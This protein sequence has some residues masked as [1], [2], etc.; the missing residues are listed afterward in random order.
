MDM[1]IT[2]LWSLV[3]QKIANGY[4]IL[5]QYLIS[6]EEYKIKLKLKET[7]GLIG[8]V[9]RRYL[10]LCIQKVKLLASMAPVGLFLTVEK[11]IL[12]LLRALLPR[13]VLWKLKTPSKTKQ[14][15]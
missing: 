14:T 7:L 9:G 3:C 5:L 15:D 10:R 1:K 11:A 12:S 6:L 4:T 2:Q 13:L 8:T